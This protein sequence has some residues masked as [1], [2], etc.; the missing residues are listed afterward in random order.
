MAVLDEKGYYVIVGRLNDHPWSR[1]H[2]PQGSRGGRSQHVAVMDVQVGLCMAIACGKHALAVCRCCT[3][4]Q[5]GSLLSGSN[6][7]GHCRQHA[8]C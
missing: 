5:M 2:F 8:W 7:K 3:E 6:S 4:L 1:Q